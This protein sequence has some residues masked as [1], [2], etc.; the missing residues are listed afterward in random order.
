M[1]D[2]TRAEFEVLVQKVEEI[3]RMLK[4]RQPFVV[5]LASTSEQ[6]MVTFGSGPDAGP[7]GYPT[8]GETQ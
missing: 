5:P 8:L 1:S 6:T 7:R 4:S 2:I 3:H